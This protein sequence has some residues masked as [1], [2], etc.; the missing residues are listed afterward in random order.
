[1]FLWVSKG[2]EINLNFFQ[3]FVK[4]DLRSF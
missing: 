1:M 2:V 4:K 3:F